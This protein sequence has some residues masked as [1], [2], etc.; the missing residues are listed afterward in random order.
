MNSLTSR[1]R[2]IVYALAIL[3]LLVPIIYLGAPLS[4]DVQPGRKNRG[5][6]RLPG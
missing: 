1:Q 4:T 5:H 3:V 2:K 6:G